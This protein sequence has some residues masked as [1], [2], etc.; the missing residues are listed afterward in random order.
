MNFNLTEDQIAFQQAAKE[1][2]VK[3][4]APHAAKWDKES[5]FPVDVIKATGELGLVLISSKSLVQEL[6]TTR[7]SDITN[8]P[9]K[10]LREKENIDLSPLKGGLRKVDLIKIACMILFIL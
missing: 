2:A 3:E 10:P 8:P 7:S 6:T 5:I 9:L 1:F 4:M